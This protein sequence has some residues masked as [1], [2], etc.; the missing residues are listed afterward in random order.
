MHITTTGSITPAPNCKKW[1][2][3]QQMDKNW[4]NHR[5][6]RNKN[7]SMWS[8]SLADIRMIFP[9]LTSSRVGLMRSIIP[10]KRSF[11]SRSLRNFSFNKT[12]PKLMHTEWLIEQLLRQSIFVIL[13]NAVYVKVVSI[14][15]REHLWDTTS[16]VPL[17]GTH[18][19][20]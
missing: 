2:Q 4:T 13:L 9:S 7:L 17:L 3:H 12:T 18:K 8:P 19:V 14:K 5:H 20:L 15:V 10:A 1:S 16:L 6:T 11:T